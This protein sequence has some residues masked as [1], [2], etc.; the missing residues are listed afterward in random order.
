VD[1]L[2]IQ[3]FVEPGDVPAIRDLAVSCAIAVT[4]FDQLAGREPA[5]D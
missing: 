4:A 2:L 5:A 1:G 3:S